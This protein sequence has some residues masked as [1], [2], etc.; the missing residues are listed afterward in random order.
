MELFK[1][2]RFAG[3][4][5]FLAATALA[6]RLGGSWP[7][8]A[9]AMTPAALCA[10]DHLLG[11]DGASPSR[12]ADREEP[13]PFA[14]RIFVCL[15]IAVLL[16]AAVALRARD[17]GVLDVLSIAGASGVSV[18]VFGMLAAHELVHRRGRG[19]RWLGLSMLACAGYMHFRIAHIHGHHVRGGSLEDPTTAR[20]G[21]SLYAFVPRSIGGQ[22][23]EAWRFEARRLQRRGEPVFGPGNRML[24]YAGLQLAVAAG[25]AALGAKAFACWALQAILAVFLLEAFNYVAH[26]GLVRRR[27]C[28]G[29]LEPLQARHAWNCSRRMSNASMFNMGRHGDHHFRPASAYQTLGPLAGAPE[30]PSGY[31]GAILLALIPPLWR[32]VM[33]PR[34]ERWSPA[35]QSGPEPS[36]ECVQVV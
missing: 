22:L 8:L 20:R 23:A 36:G 17:A 21:E 12:P 11:S 35:V 33:D 24:A 13:G 34:A 25:F 15:Q 6:I 29:V 3:P 1:P 9:M 28:R 14:P 10:L 27:D 7:L 4:F 16:L 2:L 32:G 26:Y 31:A 18:G 5:A 19:D 30:L